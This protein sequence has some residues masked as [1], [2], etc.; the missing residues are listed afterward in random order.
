MNILN[1]LA[2]GN[3]EDEAISVASMASLQYPRDDS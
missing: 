1:S 2:A 3:E